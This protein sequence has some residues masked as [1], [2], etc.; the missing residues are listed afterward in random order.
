M[1]LLNNKYIII[2]IIIM[3]FDSVYF[4]FTKLC[5]SKSI[6]VFLYK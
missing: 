5:S 3:V 1:F 6:R 4:N 2:I